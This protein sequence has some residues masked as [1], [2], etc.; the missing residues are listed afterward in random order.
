MTLRGFFA[1]VSL[2]LGVTLIA[3]AAAD[4]YSMWATIVGGGLL[5]VHTGLLFW[6]D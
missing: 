3:M 6:R 5:G 4:K 1:L 2:N